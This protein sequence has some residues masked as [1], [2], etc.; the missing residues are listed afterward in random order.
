MPRPAQKTPPPVVVDEITL[1]GRKIIVRNEEAPIGN[2]HLDPTNPRIANTIALQEG[3]QGSR[4]EDR[5]E[6]LLWND[7]D[8]RDLYRQ[9]LVNKGLIERIIIRRDH[10]VIEGNCRVVVYRR[11]RKNYPHD[12]TWSTIPARVL[13]DD[14]GEKDV[15]LLLGQMHVMG[16]NQWSGF[17]KAGHVYKLN[18]EFLLTQDEVASRLRM[19]KSKVNQLIRAF[20]AMQTH[21]LPQYPEPAS[22]RKFSYFEELF[23]KPLLRGW[24]LSEPTAVKR[25]A[26][27]VGTGKLF[28]GVHVR[29]LP[30]ILGNADALAALERG[31]Y[32]EAMKVL[33][34]ENPALLSP[35]FRK[36]S[37]M[38]QTLREARLDDVQRTRGNPAAQR[39][40]R[41]LKEA[42]SKFAELSGM[43]L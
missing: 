27:W 40:V 20:E 32:A 17:E 38:T 21:F 14:I 1:D 25:F 9:I 34:G 10:T 31:G 42:L 7:P 28:Q 16:K 37:E 8:V 3:A 19:S 35:L 5:I 39:M 11:L 23:K 30:A 41:E 24:V 43:E 4:F 12:Q 26:D 13:P 29:E 2:V 36:M 22:V 6:E 18:R 15:A 33:E